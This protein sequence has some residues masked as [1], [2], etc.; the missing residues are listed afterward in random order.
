MLL[1]LLEVNQQHGTHLVTL[2]PVHI[3]QSSSQSSEQYATFIL[4][5]QVH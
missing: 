2:R 5:Q 1:D 4:I 3:R